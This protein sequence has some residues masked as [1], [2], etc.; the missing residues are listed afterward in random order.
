VTDLP[1]PAPLIV[2]PLKPASSLH[3]IVSDLQVIFIYN[4]S[5]YGRVTQTNFEKR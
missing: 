1:L 5:V 3:V 2:G 4:S